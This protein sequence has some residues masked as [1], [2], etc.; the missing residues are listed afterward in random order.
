MQK[1]LLTKKVFT[2]VGLIIW[3]VI[4][5]MLAIGAILMFN[6]WNN[7]W[8]KIT[9]EKSSWLIK[10]STWW[11]NK[12]K[13][14]IVCNAKTWSLH[15]YW[16]TVKTKAVYSWITYNK[17]IYLNS[18]ENL[19]CVYKALHDKDNF[20]TGVA[21]VLKSDIDFRPLSWH[22]ASLNKSLNLMDYINIGI[23]FLPIG[24]YYYNGAAGWKTEFNA[25]FYG[26]NHKITVWD[27]N[28]WNKNYVWF[29]G[30][31]W[32]NWRIY[33]LKLKLNTVSWKWQVWGF[34]W[35]NWWTIRNSLAVVNN[36]SWNG[37]DVWGFVW[38]NEWTTTN[39]SAVVNSVNWRYTVWGF[40][41]YNS[42]T[43]KNS[44]AVVN[45]VSWN[46]GEV[47]GFVWQ[48]VWIIENSLVVVNSVSWT[49]KVWGL[50]WW[51]DGWTIKNSSAVV[52]SVSWNSGE[53]W[54]FVWQNFEW[55]IKNSSVVVNT[56]SWDDEVWG[57]VWFNFINWTIENSSAVVNSVNWNGN[58]WG[59]VWFNYH[60]WWTIKNSISRVLSSSSS[61]SAG[62]Y[63]N[64]NQTWNKTNFTKQ[65][66]FFGDKL[67]WSKND[68]LSYDW[69]ILKITQP[70]TKIFN[71]KNFPFAFDNKNN[72]WDKILTNLHKYRTNW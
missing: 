71:K 39:S 16:L 57:F 60:D 34:V 42:W 56:I 67:N 1:K 24:G 44:L 65:D 9:K 35:G 48:N 23:T 58:V 20:K 28:Y 43:I 53:V 68:G 55:T 22:Y 13:N 12:V 10:D 27:I 6:K 19:A 51:N 38:L 46:S 36:V 5:A 40:I 61:V 4:I 59:F 47:W 3:I 54:G 52:N 32:W 69:N 2:V 45:S 33:N 37:E 7:K 18:K 41:W 70:T 72:W 8:W 26:N 66:F 29:F 50:V 49:K 31:I 21:F 15:N 63:S 64:D 62:Y 17:I 11:N 25:D 14:K 30:Y